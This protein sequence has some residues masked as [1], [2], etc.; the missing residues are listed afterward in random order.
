M[1][2]I[3]GQKLSSKKFCTTSSSQC[4]QWKVEK[5]IP[6]QINAQHL[7]AQGDPCLGYGGAQ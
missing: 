6:H 2:L 4:G 7:N 3:K 5:N 1:E